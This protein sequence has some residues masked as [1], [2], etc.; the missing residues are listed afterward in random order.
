MGK[1]EFVKINGFYVGN[2]NAWSFE[3]KKDKKIAFASWSDLKNENGII[4]LSEDSEYKTKSGGKNGLYT[5]S[6]GHIRCI[7]EEGYDL[8]VFEIHCQ[9]LPEVEE[10]QKRGE[11]IKRESGGKFDSTLKRKSLKKIGPHWYA[12]DIPT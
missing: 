7:E 11:Y 4:V 6:R 3:N 8:Y 5:I 2:P 12:T 9:N 1:L 10:A